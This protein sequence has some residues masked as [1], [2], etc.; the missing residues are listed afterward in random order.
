MHTLVQLLSQY[1][2]LETTAGY[3]TAIDLYHT[4]LAC[5]SLYRLI[6]SSGTTFN[7][8]KGQTLCDGTGILARQAYEGHYNGL[9]GY[10]IHNWNPARTYD[11]ECFALE[12]DEVRVWA[13]KC[14]STST[15][16]CLKCQDRV[17]KECRFIP[18][19]RVGGCPSRRPHFDYTQECVNVIVYCQQCDPAVEEKTDH[20][21]CDCDRY[22]R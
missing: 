12:E 16:P 20:G 13:A 8:L 19:A 17:C 1:E 21:F 14:D 15:R 10:A 6:L 2:L 7:H 5:R 22:E 11:A 4:A 9:Q 18:R 3:L